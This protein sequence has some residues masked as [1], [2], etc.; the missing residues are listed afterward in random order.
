MPCLSWDVSAMRSTPIPPWPLWVMVDLSKLRSHRQIISAAC[1]APR[2]LGA[3]GGELIVTHTFTSQ[4][5]SD[6]Q[7]DYGHEQHVVDDG[8][9][10]WYAAGIW[11]TYDFTPKVELAFRQDY[12]KDKDGARTSGTAGLPVFVPRCG[13]RNI[14]FNADT[15]LQ[16]H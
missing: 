13:S 11:L 9:S 12:L 8:G 3:E 2:A 15:Q 7:L 10:D 1:P 6:L 4:F 5:N 14:Q 16:A